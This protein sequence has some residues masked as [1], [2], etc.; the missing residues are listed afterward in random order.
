[1]P[2]TFLM[3]LPIFILI[4]LA[5]WLIFPSKS[6]PIIVSDN[7]SN[8]QDLTELTDKIDLLEDKVSTLES[9]NS[10]LLTKINSLESLKSNSSPV[11][12]GKKSPVLLPINPGGS[13]NSTTWTNL[14]S[15]S[16]TVDP[17]DYPGYKNAFLIINLSVNV[18]QG[19]AYAQLVNT[20]NTLAIIPSRVS[21]SSYF[22]VTLTSGPFKLPAGSNTYTIQLYTQVPGYPA[23]AEDS[24]LQITY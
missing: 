18:G 21:T 11:Q 14:T 10:S 20:V 15:G 13:V 2:K 17:A 3:L 24:F 7:K 22:P 5:F 16:I 8:N 6:Q 23:Q 19:T 4:A 9:S 12:G 1:M